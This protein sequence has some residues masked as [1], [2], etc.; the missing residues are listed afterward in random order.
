VFEAKIPDS[1]LLINLFRKLDQIAGFVKDPMV[2]CNLGAITMLFLAHKFSL[3][4]GNYL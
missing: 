2:T 3:Q 1:L 4:K